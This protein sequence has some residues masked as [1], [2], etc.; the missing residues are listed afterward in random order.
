MKKLCAMLLG[1]AAVLATPAFASCEAH[2][3]K[4]RI[5]AFA[6]S[7]SVSQDGMFIKVLSG[8]DRRILSCQ[9]VGG[10]F[11]QI[12]TDMV[13]VDSVHALLLTAFSANL[14]VELGLDPTK[15]TCT[16]KVLELLPAN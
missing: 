6:H 8:V 7:L 4:G 14:E 5:T 3:C 13:Q 1:T 2:S 9:L 12:P 15:T 10:D 16:L 11:I